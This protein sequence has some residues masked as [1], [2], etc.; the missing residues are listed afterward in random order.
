MEHRLRAFAI[1]AACVALS[2]LFP[3]PLAATFQDVGSFSVPTNARE[4]IFSPAANA[5]VLKNTASEIVA[6]DLGTQGLTFRLAINQFTDMSMSPSGRYV[7]AADYGGENIGYGTPSGQSYVHRLDLV[8]KMWE[9]RTAY[10]AGNVQA[11]SD[12]QVIL[13]SLDQWVSFTN[14]DWGSGSALVPL[15]TPSGSWGPG[16]YASVY[17]G[18][19]RYD[20]RAGRLLHGN[21]NLSSPEIQAWRLVNNEFVR[22]EFTGT[23]GSAQG[24]GGT[25]A[26]ATDSSAFYYGRLQ[27]DALDV[28]HNLRVFPELI[29]AAS[30]QIAFGNGNYYDA[31]TGALLGSLPF[32]TTV[33]ALNP[34]GDDFWAYDPTTTTVHHFA[35]PLQFYTLTP[36]RVLDTRNPTGPYGGPALVA[37]AD[38]PFVFAGQCGIP[39][40]A[41]AVSSN[42]AVVSPTDGPGFLTLFPGGTPRPIFSAINY[43]AG[44]TRAKNAIV[45]LG[46]AGDV[47]VFCGQGTGTAHLVI[48]VNGFFQ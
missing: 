24:Y 5:L 7:F 23:Y 8:T 9:I 48:D 46:S 27:V 42:V 22:Q 41:K 15:N 30:G 4:L 14:N 43:I 13:K 37:G 25:V 19:F 21:S 16:Y 12:T 38:R 2:L 45:Q 17:F 28:T 11:V 44:K 47:T 32:Q 40:T 34:E 20:V 39:S 10:I 6:I 1:G 29:F 18:D 31:Q 33:Y 35:V 26:L 36:C 3:A